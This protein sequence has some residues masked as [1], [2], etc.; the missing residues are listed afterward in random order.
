MTHKQKKAFIYVALSVGHYRAFSLYTR[1][2]QSP[3]FMQL[4]HIV[5]FLQ[6]C[7]DNAKESFTIHSPRNKRGI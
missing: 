6:I 2:T 7:V 3:T 5:T 1:H 4:L